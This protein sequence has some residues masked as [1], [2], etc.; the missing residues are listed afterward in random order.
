MNTLI[1]T[2]SEVRTALTMESA[3]RA[4]EEAFA[5][6]GRGETRM[7]AK[8]YLDLPEHAGDFRAMPAYAGS[9]VGVKWVNSHPQNPRRFG[10]PTVQGVYILSDPATA[11]PLAVMDAT[12]LTA[13]RTGAAAGVATKYLARPDA[14]SV[15]FIG[16]GVQAHTALEALRGVLGRELEILAHDLD[17]EVAARF[18]AEVG[19]RAVGAEAAAGCDIVCTSTPSRTPVVERRWIR[20]GC[21]L[22]ALG[23]DGP[24]K[25]ELDSRI[26]ADA[27]IVIDEL[28][29]AQGG[30]E[31]NVPLARGELR[32]EDLY[33]TLG[34][35]VAGHKPGR[36]DPEEITV[37]DST[38][39]AIQDVAVAR[40][41][42]EQ[43]QAR[44]LG[45]SVDLLA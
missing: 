21:H 7:P 34:E 13:A 22:N 4:V 8:V 37:F 31:I 2:Q 1:L 36:Q 44:G 19:G 14:R 10:R 42:F 32:V 24:G 23:A 28:H 5:A 41:V 17:G 43:A 45:R 11:A 9:A 39:L 15:G 40:V 33:G 38:G 12:F 30:G 16:C 25:Q 29:Q 18:A 26:L 27:K 3:V 20:P 35:I 6:H